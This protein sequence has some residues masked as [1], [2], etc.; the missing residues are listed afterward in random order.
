MNKITY[1]NVNTFTSKILYYKY[2]ILLFFHINYFNNVMLL[3]HSRHYLFL[4]N[5]T[6]NFG[7]KSN[8]F[9]NII[10]TK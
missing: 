4:I 1:T 6:N 2:Q 7:I 9:Q 3:K 8:L 10:K 5:R